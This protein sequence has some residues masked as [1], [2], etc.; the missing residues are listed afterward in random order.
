M[1]GTVL[2]DTN[3]FVY[4]YT[5]NEKQKHAIIVNLLQNQL[6]GKEVFVSVQV[7]NEFYAVMT[8][9]YGFS[10]QKISEY[11]FAIIDT[12]TVAPITLETVEF[13]LGLKHTYGYSWWDS[14]LLAAALESNCE[15]FYTEDMQHGQI[16]ENRLSILNPFMQ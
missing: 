6:A 5:S 7:L 1:T 2:I 13:A 11:I 16:I 3:I 15:V 14:L 4:A 9:K 10:H 12:T 8:G